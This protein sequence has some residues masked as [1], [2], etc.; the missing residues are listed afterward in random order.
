[1]PRMSFGRAITWLAEQEPERPAL[2]H[3]GAV[4][5][6]RALEGR[7]NR[8]A[9][10][11]QGRG[12]KEGDLLHFITWGGGGWGDPLE[13]DPETVGLEIRQG[14]VTPKGARDYGVVADEDG[15]VDADA[16]EKLREEIKSSR[17]DLPLFDYGPGIDAL[18]EACEEETGLTAPIQP[19]WNEIREAAE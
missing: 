7:A 13:R 10:E 3:D 12:V 19:E 9:R 11:L 2:V 18:R 5:S 6:R 15:V 16:T 8:L 4:L 17:G 14:L 1:M